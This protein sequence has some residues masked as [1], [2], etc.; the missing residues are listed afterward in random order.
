M[1]HEDILALVNQLGKSAQKAGLQLAQASTESKNEALRFAARALRHQ[2]ESLK[3]ANAIDLEHA[4]KKERP[5]A[6]LDRLRLD[7]SRIENMALA[8]ENIATFPDPVGRNLGKWNRPNGLKME[9]IA[10]PIGVIA[11]VYE[12]RPNVGSDASA[13]CIKS[14]NT[15]ILRG[16]SDSLNSSRVIVKCMRSG[17]EKAGLPVEAIQMVDDPERE[18]VGALLR[19]TDY[20]DLLIPRGGKG[21]VSL[22]QK[23]ARVPTLL[24]LEGNCHTYIHEKADL[25]KALKVVQNAKLRRTGICGATESLVID[26]SIATLFLPRLIDTLEGCEFRGEAD[27]K[28]IDDRFQLADEKDWDLEYLDAILSVKIVENLEAGLLF[29]AQHSSQHTDA[30]ITEDD[31]A[32]ESFFRSIDS[33]VLMHN[34]ST[35]FSDGGEFGFGAEIGIATGKLHARGPVGLEQLTSYKYLVRG[36]GQVRP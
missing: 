29:V 12:S 3:E 23:E 15:I 34:T 7:E 21:L 10:V 6:F 31:N 30:I 28:A 1:T 26:R 13:L 33:A 5:N 14:G 36:D 2:K 22:V 19:C 9:R 18:I 35:Q 16:G 25:E 4:L 8:L 11:M 24:H 20:I 27:A 17:L 32:A